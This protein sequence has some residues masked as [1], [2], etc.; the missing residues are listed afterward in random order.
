MNV[1][2]DSTHLQPDWVVLDDQI[3][4]KIRYN[5]HFGGQICVHTQHVHEQKTFG[6]VNAICAV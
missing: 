1:Q 3:R 4:Y 5:S 2:A 6:S